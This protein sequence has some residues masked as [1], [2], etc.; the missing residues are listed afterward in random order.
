[1]QTLMIQVDSGS[2][3]KQLSSVLASMDFVKKVSSVRS[4]KKLIAALQEHDDMKASIIK[5]KNKAIAKYLQ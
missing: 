2:K 3:A 5:R 4:P 1:M